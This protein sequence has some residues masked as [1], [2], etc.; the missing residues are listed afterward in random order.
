MGII[1]APLFNRQPVRADNSAKRRNHG[2]EHGREMG[3]ESLCSPTLLPRSPA[4]LPGWG[5]RA[6]SIQRARARGAVGLSRR[7][8]R[9]G[10]L[11]EGVKR[12]KR[13]RV[14]QET[15]PAR[16]RARPK[17]L[18]ADAANRKRS[19]SFGA[20]ARKTSRARALPP[21]RP[22][23][24]RPVWHDK[25]RRGARSRAGRRLVHAWQGPQQHGTIRRDHQRNPRARHRAPGGRGRCRREVA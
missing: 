22:F 9:V 13:E 20:R 23:R 18:P 17:D 10:W 5:T 4:L 1:H 7:G 24:A 3:H 15:G 2:R 25:T 8:A 12:R 19:R 21:L 11:Q 6:A 16:A 14:A